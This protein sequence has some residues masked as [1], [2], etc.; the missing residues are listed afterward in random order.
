METEYIEQVLNEVP[1]EGLNEVISSLEKRFSAEFEKF[2]P[3]MDRPRYSKDI[4]KQIEK[5][6]LALSV[7]E[8]L[9]ITNESF[10]ECSQAE[11]KKTE[12]KLRLFFKR[13]A[14]LNPGKN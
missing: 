12:S 13:I 3:G 8:R 2:V 14:L 6:I 4:V 1:E 9:R 5:A 10:V 7:T 11:P